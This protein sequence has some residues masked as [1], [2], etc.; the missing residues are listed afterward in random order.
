MDV[1]AMALQIKMAVEVDQPV[2]GQDL[3][4]GVTLIVV[5]FEEQPTSRGQGT[6]SVPRQAPDGGQPIKPSIQGQTRLVITNNGIEPIHLRRR[7]VWRV[8]QHQIQAS[9]PA[10]ERSK[11]IPLEETNATLQAGFAEV[12]EGPC[13]SSW[14]HIHGQSLA[15]RERAGQAHRQAATACAQICP[16]HPRRWSGLRSIGHQN[17]GE[18]NQ[19]LGL[20]PGDEN[21]WSHLKDE[22][23]PVTPAQEILQGN[24]AAQ[25]V[26]PE[27]LNLPAWERQRNGGRW[28]EPQGVE[29]SRGDAARHVQEPIEGPRLPP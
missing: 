9:P 4:H 13:Q 23:P 6:W 17:L 3:G 19:G 16:Q 20:R 29:L 2:T 15:A 21:P 22:I 24:R 27:T 18:I 10:S 7:D 11:P 12:A 1:A 28:M 8:R 5:V 25:V 26:S 14:A